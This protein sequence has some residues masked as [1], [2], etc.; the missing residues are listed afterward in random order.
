MSSDGLGLGENRAPPAGVCQL[1]ERLIR[2]ARIAR[3]ARIA[4]ATIFA[5]ARV[6]EK[7]GSALPANHPPSVKVATLAT[8]GTIRRARTVAAVNLV[9]VEQLVIA[10]REPTERRSLRFPVEPQPHFSR[11]PARFPSHSCLALAREVQPA[12]DAEHA[13]PVPHVS[14]A[15]AMHPVQARA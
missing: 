15:A 10:L 9:A 8:S 5:A 4:R 1:Y 11:V 12:K 13:H 14:P 3:I 6:S 2:P 7:D